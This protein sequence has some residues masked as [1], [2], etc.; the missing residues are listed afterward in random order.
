[1]IN[2][3][4]TSKESC[5]YT[6]SH[7]TSIDVEKWN[8]FIEYDTM[9]HDNLDEQLMEFLRQHT[10]ND[11]I[12]IPIEN[13]NFICA[14]ITTSA[15][16]CKH[17]KDKG[18]MDLQESYKNKDGE[19][20]CFLDEHGIVV[21]LEKKTLIYKSKEYSISDTAG[22][23]PLGIVGNKFFFDYS[24]CGFKYIG[25]YKR[26]SCIDRCPEIIHNIG[27]LLGLELEKEWGKN[28]S[29]YIIKYIVRNE[30]LLNGKF[31]EDSF[32]LLLDAYS[33]AV[34]NSIHYDVAI[35]NNGV[36]IPANDIVSIKKINS[37]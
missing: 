18:L 2:Y 16:G 19:L 37:L 23:N 15:N 29:V 31:S 9:R 17:I 6:L 22:D 13:I 27:Q 26:Y 3:D 8:D 25:D 36:Q 12:H 20:R 21:N 1:M 7:M 5:I 14:H 35:T 33:R 32:E 24:L 10:G 28:R 4:V 34:E 11:S 30:Q